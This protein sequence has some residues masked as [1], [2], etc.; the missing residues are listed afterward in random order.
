MAASV[1][2]TFDAD[3]NTISGRSDLK[4]SSD[5]VQLGLG[6][7]HGKDMAPISYDL[8][9]N[10]KLSPNTSANTQLNFNEKFDFTK[11]S[12]SLSTKINNHHRLSLNTNFED[13][14]IRD[15]G[16]KYTY[17]KDNWNV[18]AGAK[19]DFMNNRTTGS[20]SAGYELR[21]NISL[22]ITGSTDGASDHRIGAGISVKF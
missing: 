13:T 4:Y 20:L 7:K 8:K 21:D 5:A 2:A 16:A 18:S 11:G 6:A 14:G 12:A 3:M 15:L 17:N 22:G 19:H 1:N 10:F 9:G